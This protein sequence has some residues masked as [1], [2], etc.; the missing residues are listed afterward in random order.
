MLGEVLEGSS[1]SILLAATMALPMKTLKAMAMK[2]QKAVKALKAIKAM[3]AMKVMKAMK[4]SEGFYVDEVD[5][6]MC[7]G[8]L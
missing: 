4:F 7:M 5:A 3:K 2:A 6:L 1:Q 8:R